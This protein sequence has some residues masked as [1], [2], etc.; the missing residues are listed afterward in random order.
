MIWAV[1]LNG[2]ILRATLLNYHTQSAGPPEKVNIVIIPE[3]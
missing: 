3:T 1:E 2:S